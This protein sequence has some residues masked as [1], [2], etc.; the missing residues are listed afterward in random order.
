[1]DYSHILQRYIL[2]FSLIWVTLLSKFIP[3][4]L[5][6]S[7]ILL[8][9][10]FTRFIIVVFGVV[11]KFAFV[12]IFLFTVV[13]MLKISPLN[14]CFIADNVKVFLYTFQ[15]NN[16]INFEGVAINKMLW[17]SWAMPFCAFR[18]I[19]FLFYWIAK[20]LKS[21]CGIPWP[22]LIHRNCSRIRVSCARENKTIF[23]I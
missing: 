10:Y 16:K 23:I 12:F 9:Y 3:E 2:L 4:I 5:N 20:I 7:S 19:L 21:F 11:L 17:Q 22:M 1:M 18:W 13:A 15:S 8:G 14:P 6:I